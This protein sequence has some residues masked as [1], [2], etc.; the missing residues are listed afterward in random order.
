MYKKWNILSNGMVGLLHMLLMGHLAEKDLFG[1]K[2]TQECTVS[3]TM[4]EKHMLFELKLVQDSLGA[5]FTCQFLVRLSDVTTEIILSNESFV[6]MWT[7]DGSQ[8]FDL[9]RTRRLW[10][11]L[12]SGS[13]VFT[14]VTS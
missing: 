8:I 9:W 1:A 2:L 14:H 6:T 3:T 11:R 4:I 7:P 5:L 13:F 10:L 12:L